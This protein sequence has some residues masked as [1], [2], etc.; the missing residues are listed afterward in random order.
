MGARDALKP[1]TKNQLERITVLAAT[2]QH[3]AEQALS[4]L[5]RAMAARVAA[6]FA[7]GLAL[8]AAAAW[9]LR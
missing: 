8:G 7:A 9:W 5:R 3:A 1:Y 2:K 4:H 6:G